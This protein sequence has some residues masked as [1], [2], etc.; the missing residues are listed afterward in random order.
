MR[1]RYEVFIDKELKI[2]INRCDLCSDRI[3]C[4][5]DIETQIDMLEEINNS[6]EDEYDKQEPKLLL[7]DYCRKEYLIPA[8]PL[9]LT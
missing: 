5:D 3:M 8:Y 6:Y 4:R 1:S 9:T 7:C 2:V